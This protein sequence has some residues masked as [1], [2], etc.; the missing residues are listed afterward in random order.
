M[1]ASGIPSFHPETGGGAGIRVLQRA[2]TVAPIRRLAVDLGKYADPFLHRLT[3][4]RLGVRM[5]MPFAS[6]TTTGA[7]SGQ[8]RTTAVLYFNDAADVI[9]IASNWGGARHPAWYHNLKANP[10]ARLARGDRS[11]NYTATEVT[12]ELARERLFAL[13]ER[14]YPGYQDYRERTAK[15]GRRIPIMRLRP[16]DA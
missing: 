3:R 16:V 13:A 1:T 9:L 12:D 6:M 8:P 4:G 7:K 5:A 11:G 10:A 14:V 2:L 15:I